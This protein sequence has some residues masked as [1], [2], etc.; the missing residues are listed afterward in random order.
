MDALLQRGQ[1]FAWGQN[2]QGQLGLGRVGHQVL[3]P[4]CVTSLSGTPVAQIAAGTAHSFALSLSG[5]VFGWGRNSCGQLGLGD[6]EVRYLPT[7][8]KLLEGQKVVYISCGAQHT[9]LLTKDGRVFTCGAGRYGQL[10]HNTNCDEIKPRIIAGL[11]GSKVCQIACGSYHT[12]VL[13]APPGKVYSFGHEEKR[14]LGNGKNPH[15]FVSHPVT[16]FIGLADGLGPV[17]GTMKQSTVRAARPFRISGTQGVTPRLTTQAP[18]TGNKAQRKRRRDQ[19][20]NQLSKGQGPSGQQSTKKK[21]QPNS[22][23]ETGSSSSEQDRVTQPTVKRIF[24]GAEQGFALCNVGAVPVS[25]EDQSSFIPMKRIA[26]VEDSLLDKWSAADNEELGKNIKEEID[27]LFSSAASLNGSFLETSDDHFN[28]GRAASGL[29]MSAVNVWFEKLGRNHR[30]LQE[31]TNAVENNLI[32]SLTASPVG[33]EVLRVYLVLPELIHILIEQSRVVKLTCLLSSAIASLEESQ[34]EVLESWWSN[35]NEF[36]FEKLVTMYKSVSH[37]LFQQTSSKQSGFPDEL[38]NCLDILQRLFKISSRARFPMPASSF[39]IDPTD[40]L[41]D[42]PV[43]CEAF[44]QLIPYPCIFNMQTK[45]KIF[46]SLARLQLLGSLIANEIMTLCNY[47]IP[48]DII[49]EIDL[50]SLQI[51]PV[52]GNIGTSN[53]NTDAS[54]GNANAWNDD[55]NISTGIT[56]ASTANIDAANSDIGI[57]AGV[58]QTSTGNIGASARNIASIGDTDASTGSID[59]STGDIDISTGETDIPTGNTETSTGNIYISTGIIYASTGNNV[60]PNGNNDISTGNIAA[61]NGNSDVSTGNIVAPNGNCDVSTG[62]IVAPNGNSVISTGNIVAPNGN[63]EVSTGNM[64][65]PNGNSDISTGNI[66]APNGNSDASAGNMVTPN[67]NSD[68]STG[69]VVAPNGNSVITTGNNVAPNGNSDISTGNIVAPNGNCDVSTGNI[70]APNGNSDISTGNIVAPNGNS[71]ISTGNVVAP[72][73]NIDISTGNI[74]APNGNSD[75]SAGNMVAPNGNSDISTGNIV[76]PNGNSVITTGNNVAPNGNSDISTGNIVAPNGNTDAST[77]NIAPVSLYS[78]DDFEPDRDLLN[79][80]DYDDYFSPQ[81][82]LL[83]CCLYIDRKEILQDTLTQLRS[84]DARLNFLFFKVNFKG[85][86]ALDEGGVSQEFFSIITEELCTE[87][88]IFKFYEESRL[89]WFPEWNP[90]IDDIFRLVGILCWISLYHGFVA[91][92]H[93]PLALY[94]KLLNVQ[95]NLDDLKDLSPTLG[96]NLQDLLDY[97]NDDIE[98][99]LCYNFTIGRELIDGSIIEHELIPNGKNIPVKKNNRKQFVDCYVDY[100]FNVSVEKHFKAFSAEFWRAMILPVVDIFQPVE[101][102]SL[103]H[104]NTK[105]DWQLLADNTKYLGYT[106]TDDVIVNFWKMFRELTEEEK[107]Q[108]LVFLT[109]CDRVP[110]GGMGSLRIVVRHEPTD[111]PDLYFPAAHTCNRMLDLPK[112]SSLQILREKFLRAIGCKREFSIA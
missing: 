100:V 92:F 26:T 6:T 1:V 17:H 58:I 97:E 56:A 112:Y 9:A 85:E 23:I 44:F 87:P 69:N 7:Y 48:D 95:P 54:T 109:G 36:F 21:E 50:S 104:G 75:A 101:L 40:V 46:R 94:K 99:V 70:V 72:N 18:A 19:L 77:G 108:F 81:D 96:R 53:G 38:C 102:M 76:A 73:G 32:P 55:T 80:G 4:Q 63:C 79:Y 39:Y 61:P 45:I 8:A 12:L 33:V 67:G 82:L 13:V 57:S 91:D 5:S 84:C 15:Q 93:F 31:V 111:D 106:E 49:E 60:A 52:T 83:G 14:Q 22:P 37:R 86:P 3:R 62:N 10:G 65:A 78:I 16:F 2:I 71:D 27:L 105:Y 35:L 89:V 28:T 90:E 30:L 47:E 34:L 51:C 88:K 68:I 24:A 20:E 29:D 74:V 41:G 25:P 42:V 107:K 98:E 64:V 66:V 43:V 11:L 59:T 103:I 110:V